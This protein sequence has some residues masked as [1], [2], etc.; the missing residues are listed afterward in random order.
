MPLWRLHWRRRSR[1]PQ[2]KVLPDGP[3]PKPFFPAV[4]SSIVDSLDALS[5]RRS[6]ARG[7]WSAG[8]HVSNGILKIIGGLP[9][10]PGW[11]QETGVRE[12]LWCL[13]FVILIHTN[14]PDIH[15]GSER[16][17]MVKL[18]TRLNHLLT[19]QM[20]VLCVPRSGALSRSPIMGAYLEP[21]ET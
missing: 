2:L 11:L 9:K 17:T 16:P 8:K 20:P 3:S 21:L 15:P 14:F 4:I 19:A 1:G 12:I 5:H 6:T 10:Q 13:Q 18:V 7:F